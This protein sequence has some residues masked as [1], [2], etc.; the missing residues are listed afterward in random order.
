M[1]LVENIARHRCK[2]ALECETYLII[3]D[4]NLT[5]TIAVF[6]ELSQY[7]RIDWNFFAFVR[8]IRFGSL[9]RTERQVL[10]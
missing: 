10:R 9:H 8:K 3:I 2:V 4:R 1:P 5:S 7:C 6:L